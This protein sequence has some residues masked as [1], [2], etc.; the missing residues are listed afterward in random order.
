MPSPVPIIMIEISIPPAIEPIIIWV[1]ES[2]VRE[3]EASFRLV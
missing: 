1:V 3:L 2:I